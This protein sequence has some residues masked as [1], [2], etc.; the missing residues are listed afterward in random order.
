[1]KNT[2]SG[3]YTRFH[4]I[5]FV[6]LFGGA[7]MILYWSVGSFMF[8]DIFNPLRDIYFYIS[9]FVF[10][11][12]EP[13]RVLATE[14]SNPLDGD[15]ISNIN[16]AMGCFVVTYISLKCWVYLAYE[17][18]KRLESRIMISKFGRKKYDALQRCLKIRAANFKRLNSE[19]AEI[20]KA[21][22]AHYEKWKNYYKSSLSFDEW[23]E[24]VINSSE[25]KP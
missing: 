8:T 3:F 23:K 15:W 7:M 25:N 20:E 11:K 16:L 17:I 4:V 6:I 22:F 21:E 24:K 18:S 10:S 19:K 13:N 1:M 2:I 5:D 9:K 14:F 12:V